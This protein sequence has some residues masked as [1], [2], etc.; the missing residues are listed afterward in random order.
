[1]LHTGLPPLLA[2]LRHRIAGALLLLALVLPLHAGDT[3]PTAF[4]E[5]EVKATF[6]YNFAHFVRW[7]EGH[8][9]R[10]GEPFRYCVLD[11]ALAPLLAKAVA[12]ETLDGHPL[13]VQRQPDPRNFQECHLIYF[14]DQSA[15]SPGAQTELLRR[16]TGPILTVSDQP[17]FAARGGMIT[18]THK[19]GRIH[20]V[21]NTD[22]IER[23]EL[24]VSAK[25]L[26]LAT[27]TRDGKGSAP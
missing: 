16:L 12:G 14:G 1:M 27:L 20:P 19:R 17:G 11:D 7:P 3:S 5:N 24:R 6:V 13:V 22:A 18:L 10:P 23:T 4:A 25:L 26:N 8:T 9:L 21:I 15:I 2:R